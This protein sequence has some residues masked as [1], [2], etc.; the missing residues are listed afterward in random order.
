MLRGLIEDMKVNYKGV[1]YSEGDQIEF[2]NGVPL[3]G[4]LKFGRYGDNEAYVNY[5]HLGF[6]VEFTH[7]VLEKERTD[8]E[9][10]PDCIDYLNG[11]KVKTS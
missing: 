1:E 5:N 11:V 2:N 4:I 9:T 7:I 8:I 6:Y 3:K 10:L